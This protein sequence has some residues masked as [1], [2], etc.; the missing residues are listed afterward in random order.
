MASAAAD[1]PKVVDWT[2]WVDEVVASFSA[3][4]KDKRRN[5]KP[6]VFSHSFAFDPRCIP[7]EE[8]ERLF[9]LLRDAGH[10]FFD[11]SDPNYETERLH[12]IGTVGFGRRNPSWKPSCSYGRRAAWQRNDR[13]EQLASGKFKE[14]DYRLGDL[15][16][17]HELP[18]R[19]IL[20]TATTF[21]PNDKGEHDFQGEEF[22]IECLLGS[23]LSTRDTD[24]CEEKKC[25]NFMPCLPHPT[26]KH[27]AICLH[28][29]LVSQGFPE[30]FERPKD[31]GDQTFETVS[32]PFYGPNPLTDDKPE[33]II[34]RAFDFEPLRRLLPEK[35]DFRC[36]QL[37]H[38]EIGGV[39][40]CQV[41]EEPMGHRF[42]DP[43]PG[44]VIFP[45]PVRT[46]MELCLQCFSDHIFCS[47]EN[48]G[49][50]LSCHKVRP[51]Y[52]NEMCVACCF[53]KS[54]D[55]S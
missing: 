43:N 55:K 29:L 52:E 13:E 22:C 17:A 39:A 8:L 1:A 28:C 5:K 31:S 2:K 50:C 26:K 33:D 7:F 20:Y 46:G 30:E 44:I 6:W 54:K 9:Y 32:V 14:G 19:A 37:F 41:C 12:T 36:L 53:G 16:R 18:P 21:D 51:E 48:I 24:T 47:G 38:P 45:E 3:W 34:K 25:N 35:A 11:P 49:E 40:S 42:N 23:L 27:D 15:C 10:P 4:K